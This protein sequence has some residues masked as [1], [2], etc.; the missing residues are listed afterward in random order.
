MS[1]RR[2]LHQFTRI[3]PV[4]FQN[5]P[6]KRRHIKILVANVP[7]VGQESI[8]TENQPTVVQV[9]LSYVDMAL[10][11]LKTIKLDINVFVTLVGQTKTLKVLAP[12]MLMNVPKTT[13]LVLPI[14]WYN[15]LTFL[16]LILVSIV[17]Q[18]KSINILMFSKT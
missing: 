5:P 6:A 2:Y 14:L 15:V 3:L 12:L 17:H 16:D 11:F 8:V 4:S 13:H 1:K 10:A 7:P 9:V 18:V